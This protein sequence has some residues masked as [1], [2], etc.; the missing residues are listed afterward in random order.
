MQNRVYI[1]DL[2]DNIG[3]E[4]I[5]AGWV[6]IRRDQGK[7]VFFDMRDM[8]GLVQCVVLPSHAEAI[9]KAKEIRPEWVL[10]ITGMV[11]KRPDKNVKAGVLNG[12]VELEVTDIEVLSK[13]ET[14]AI[15]VSTDGYEIG[16]EH[17][18]EHRYLDLRRGRM[19]KNIRN[20]HKVVKFIRDYLD[21]E[22]FI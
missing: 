20:R 1:K 17:R 12:E 22:N 21:K 2:K 7:M 14:P 15:D 6:N 10:K 13:A 3:K 18:L 5:I 8:T 11:N 4:I 9:E 19:Q 16:E